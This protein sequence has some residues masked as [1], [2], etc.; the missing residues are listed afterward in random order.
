MKIY[1]I[2]QELFS[3]QTYPG[4]KKPEYTRVCDISN[5]DVVNITNIEMCV[6]NGTHVD[7]P[8]HF[9]KEREGIDEISLEKFVGPCI[10]VEI[11]GNITGSIMEEILPKETQTKRLLVKSDGDITLEAAKIINDRKLYLI[12]VEGQSVGNPKH[13]EDVHMELLRE[14]VVLLEGLRL[15]DVACGQYFLFAA[16]IN[17]AKS[18]GAP[19]RAVLVDFDN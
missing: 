7:A 19:C 9:F 17:M 1:D 18:D 15:G 8:N 3:S 10:V 16:P 13:P 2:S 5:G 4:D 14:K 12:G 11:D 6:H